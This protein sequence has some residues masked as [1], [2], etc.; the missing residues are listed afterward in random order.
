M[1]NFNISTDFGTQWSGAYTLS[2][3]QIS[4]DKNP[5]DNDTENEGTINNNNVIS[6]PGNIPNNGE[7]IPDQD[8]IEVI[9]PDGLTPEMISPIISSCNKFIEATV[10]KDTSG[11]EFK[12]NI[13][14][15][16]KNL[17]IT[18]VVAVIIVIFYFAM[19]KDSDDNY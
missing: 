7:Y 11:S 10:L 19:K 6:V 4:A 18:L 12:N 15:T 16:G 1:I 9:Y 8:D 14:Q 5:L 17:L 2:L 3:T 13:S